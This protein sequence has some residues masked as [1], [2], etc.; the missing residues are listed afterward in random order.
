MSDD[1]PKAPRVITL[2]R[3]QKI[4]RLLNPLKWVALV[5]AAVSAVTFMFGILDSQLGRYVIPSVVGGL[6]AVLLFAFI[7]GF[8]VIPDVTPADNSVY[9]Q[10][11]TRIARAAYWMLAILTGAA[12][13]GALVA[14]FRLMAIWSSGA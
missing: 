7:T 12:S 14:T 3:L 1:K 9:E 5:G 8:Q 10:L 4:A 6:W 11:K 13:L 2:E